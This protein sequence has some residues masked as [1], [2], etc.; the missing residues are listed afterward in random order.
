MPGT[1]TPIQPPCHAG[2]W[3]RHRSASHRSC[4]C[5]SSVAAG[6]GRAT[7]SPGDD[8]GRGPGRVHR[9]GR[10]RPDDLL[11]CLEA[12]G[13]PVAATDT[14]PM[15]VEVP[16]EGLEVGPLAGNTGGDSEQGA[17][18]WVFTERRRRRREPRDHHPRG[19]GHADELG[20]RQR[21]RPPVLRAPPRATTRRSRASRIACPSDLRPGSSGRVPRVLRRPG[22]GCPAL[23]SVTRMKLSALRTTPALAIA[24]GALLLSAT[25]GAVAAGSS[26]APTSRTARSPPR[27][28]RTRRS[29]SATSP[30]GPRPRCRVPPD[31]PAPTASADGSPSRSCL[32]PSRPAATGTVVVDCPAGTKVTGGIVDWSEGYDPVS[33][34]MPAP[35]PAS[36]PTGTTP[37]GPPTPW[38]R[39][40]SAPT[41]S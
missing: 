7:R 38:S 2:G 18:L 27:T 39:P 5:S 14:T 15:G 16:V 25:G 30:R 37:P 40:S 11:D 10:H 3:S 12:A 28:S 24:T 31:P 21:R 23:P 19:R 26:P 22:A 13:L 33:M 36:G 4:S 1:G 32:T 17:D 34:R 9:R 8:T 20:R 35:T 6:G 41:V 29:P